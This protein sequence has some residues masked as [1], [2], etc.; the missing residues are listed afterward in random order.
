MWRSPYFCSVNHFSG[1]C[2]IHISSCLGYAC[3]KTSGQMASRENTCEEWKWSG[4][5]TFL[6]KQFVGITHFVVFSLSNDSSFRSWEF[7]KLFWDVWRRPTMQ[8]SNYRYV[9]LKL[10][11]VCVWKH[12]DD[13]IV[14]LK[15]R[16]KSTK[17]TTWNRHNQLNI[18]H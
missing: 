2:R 5:P 9:D 8:K 18:G 1:L 7:F 6:M 3:E 11:L 4:F 14:L 16:W 13:F 12:L 15:G 17:K 10:V